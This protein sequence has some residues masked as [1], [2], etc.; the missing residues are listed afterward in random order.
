MK[1]Y[2]EVVSQAICLEEMFCVEIDTAYLFK[3]KTEHYGVKPGID[4]EG[5][6]MI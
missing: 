1:N 3:E 6:I 2:P 4:M 5:V